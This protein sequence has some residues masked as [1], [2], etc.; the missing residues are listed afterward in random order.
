MI[1]V[2]YSHNFELNLWIVYGTKIINGRPVTRQFE[3][4]KTEKGAKNYCE[5][6]TQKQIAFYSKKGK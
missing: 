3:S 4:F 5:R 6:Y 1:T 2:S